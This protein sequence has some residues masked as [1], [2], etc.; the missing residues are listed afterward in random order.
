M[1]RSVAARDLIGGAT[2]AAILGV[3][4]SAVSNY[5][6]RD[7]WPPGFPKPAAHRGGGRGPRGTVPLWRRSAIERYARTHADDVARRRRYGSTG[8]RL[9]LGERDARNA[10]AQTLRELRAV[11]D[12]DIRAR[13][14]AGE[15]LAAI[16]DSHGLT[17]ERVRQLTVGVGQTFT[18]GGLPPR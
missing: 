3:T 13:R 10:T 5:A 12:A 7:S 2:V 16:G 9:T 1:A 6:A 18:E 17:R 8:V 14:A 4:P 15:T 11:R